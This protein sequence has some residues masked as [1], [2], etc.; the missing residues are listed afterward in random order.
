[1]KIEQQLVLQSKHGENIRLNISRDLREIY[2]YITSKLDIALRYKIFKEITVILPISEMSIK[3]VKLNSPAYNDKKLYLTAF[4]TNLTSA[5][6]PDTVYIK[7]RYDHFD[8][9][10]YQT[11]KY[12]SVKD[13]LNTEKLLIS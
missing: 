13:M 6:K 4:I 7:W 1:M 12:I 9:L 3:T 8:G 11:D 5:Y 2:L 10:T